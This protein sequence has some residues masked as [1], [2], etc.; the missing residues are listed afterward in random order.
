[1]QRHLTLS[2]ECCFLL[3]LCKLLQISVG[4]LIWS[5]WCF[6]FEWVKKTIYCSKENYFREVNQ[7][8]SVTTKLGNLGNCLIQLFFLVWFCH[9]LQH[10]LE[11]IEKT[12]P[13]EW[14]WGSSKN[15]HFF[16]STFQLQ[17]LIKNTLRC[18]VTKRKRFL[19]DVKRK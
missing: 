14:L 5:S 2:L 1:M 17:M 4:F 19:I 12:L 18:M 11:D 16:Y 3:Q 7:Y 15:C 10:H 13:T 8:W 6:S 9:L